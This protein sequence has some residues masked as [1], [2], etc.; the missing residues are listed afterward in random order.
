MNVRSINNFLSFQKQNRE[1]K[2]KT[3]KSVFTNTFKPE[4]KIPVIG[5]NIRGYLV[6]F[7]GSRVDK[8]LDR[9]YEFN[10]NKM[11]STVRRYV[12]SLDD[13]TRLT[14]IEAQKRA[15]SLLKNANTIQDI[16]NFFPDE[17]LFKNLIDPMQTKA[18]IGLL[19][20]VRENDELLALSN[21][22]VLKSKENLTVYL[23]K[24]IFLEAKTYDEINNDLEKDLDED[25]KAD[26]RFKYPNSAYIQDGTLKGLGIK[27]PNQNYLNSLRYT[28]EG[29]SDKVGEYI[30]EVQKSFWA[31]LSDSERTARAK[32]S[33]EKFEI[34]WNS[35]TQ[36]E[37][38]DMIAAQMTALDMLKDFKKEQK[39]QEKK[40]LLVSSKNNEQIETNSAQKPTQRIKTGSSKLSQDELFVKWATNNL[41]LFEANL[42]EAQKDTLHLKRMHILS[43]R[44]ANMTAE[45]RTDY[46]SKMKSGSEPLRFAM[47]D[48]WNHS[49]DLIRELSAFMQQKQITKPADL[50]FSSEEFSQ[51][52]SEIMTEFWSLHEDEAKEFGKKIILA[53][54]KVNLAI[55][56]GTFEELKKE[57]N[58]DRYQRIKDIDSEKNLQSLKS[59]TE[60]PKT[61]DMP[62][63][64][65]KFIFAYNNKHFAIVKQLPQEYL[66][67]YFK[68]TLSEIPEEYVKLWTK[69]ILSEYD[70]SDEERLKLQKITHMGSDKT[71]RINNPMCVAAADEL[72][73]LT[74][75]PNVF[76]L[77]PSEIKN[78]L[79]MYSQGQD[80]SVYSNYANKYI[81]LNVT[82]KKIDVNKMSKLYSEYKQPLSDFEIDK[83][84]KNYFYQPDINERVGSNLLVK[85][86]LFAK[87]SE[88][89]MF[90]NTATP[91]QLE[92]F[93]QT[94]GKSSLILF[95]DKNNYPPEVKKAFYNKFKIFWESDYPDVNMNCCFD[96]PNAFEKEKEYK[97]LEYKFLQKYSFVPQAF[98]KEYF[99]EVNKH[100]RYENL[101]PDEFEKQ[102]CTKRKKYDDIANIVILPKQNMPVSLKLQSLAMEE[103]LSD[104]LFESTQNERLYSLYFEELADIM[105]SVLLVKKFPSK[106]SFDITGSDKPLELTVNKKPALYKILA[107]Y[108]DYLNELL[109]INKIPETEDT[110]NIEEEI[111]FTLNP[112]ED[113]SLRDKNVKN[114]IEGYEL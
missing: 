13:K 54:E 95:D 1:Q 88:K 11:P 49:K 17:E 14:P 83:I 102:V 39:Q 96:K 16:K 28:R 69:A 111:L 105:E 32:K 25:F 60:E 66:D 40:D 79:M 114:R 113:N 93:L 30:S 71:Q 81:D 59:I 106:L 85:N 109:E 4:P 75:N 101:Q 108:K 80:F 64:M 84:I 57:I 35:H 92:E 5:S 2:T 9:F 20:S 76:Q 52:Q 70:V 33:V 41:K 63:Y 47:I 91:K 58:R 27:L 94:F 56:R 74:K 67:D 29:Y 48:A 24:K 8:G 89:P 110:Q 31:S 26:F 15:Y 78:A 38:L 42:S 34:W 18:S 72:Y 103:A 12:E 90:E 36:N 104:V 53:W 43:S 7:G 3:N 73:S 10:K 37:K 77:V 100:L 21:Q 86:D 22:G 62:E 99:A 44:W 19:A 65:Q 87:H 82:K 97:N 46:I 112:E 68:T 107:L 45:E 50:L 61:N 51:Y 55:S 6:S 23:V 98:A